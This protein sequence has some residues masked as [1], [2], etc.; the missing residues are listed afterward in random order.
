MRTS[1]TKDRGG[2]ALLTATTEQRIR[3]ILEDLENVRENLLALSDDIWL[4]IDH[5][6]N[7]A[8]EEGVRF[9]QQYNDRMDAFARV[10][11]ELS[12]MVQQFTN[13]RTTTASR[14]EASSSRTARDRVI[15]ELDRRTPHPVIEDFTFKRPYGFSL[16]EH[17]EID[18][19]TWR[20]LYENLLLHLREVSPTTFH[21]LPDRAETVS[22]RGSPHFARDPHSL[23]VASELADGIHAEINLSANSIRD[24]I[25]TVLPYFGYDEDDLSIYLRED[26]DA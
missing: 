1:R 10:A 14:E 15:A 16:T 11:E 24:M 5:N 2:F 9:K 19:R 26:R 21:S 3:T 25:C 17:A 18:L 20:S 23:R 12:V 6:D 8:M 13:I 22:R 4:S 7:D